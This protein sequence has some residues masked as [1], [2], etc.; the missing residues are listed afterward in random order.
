MISLVPN[1][2]THKNIAYAYFF[3]KMAQNVTVPNPEDQPLTTH[4]QSAAYTGRV[5][6]GYMSRN[7]RAT[8]DLIGAVLDGLTPEQQRRLVET[9]IQR[10]N[11]G[12]L[13]PVEADE[14][15]NYNNNDNNVNIDIID[16]TNNGANQL[17]NQQQNN[18]TGQQNNPGLENNNINGAANGSNRA[19]F[20]DTTPPPNSSSSNNAQQRELITPRQHVSDRNYL[21]SLPRIGLGHT[22]SRHNNGILRQDRFVNENQFRPTRV[23]VER[24]LHQT[25]QHIDELNQQHNRYQHDE[26]DS[27]SFAETR[28]A[29]FNSY[30]QFDYMQPRDYDL[31]SNRGNGRSNQIGSHLPPPPPPSRPTDHRFNE[32]NPSGLLHLKTFDGK[33]DVIEFIE[34]FKAHAIG[35]NWNENAQ[36]RSLRMSLAGRAL[37]VFSQLPESETCTIDRA[38][39][40]LRKHYTPGQAELVTKYFELRPSKNQSTREFLADLADCYHNAYPNA[41]EEQ[42]ILDLRMRVKK[43]LPAHKQFVIPANSRA[44]WLTTIDDVSSECPTLFA[45]DSGESPLKAKSNNIKTDD[46]ELN[47]NFLTNKNQFNRNK[48]TD[49]QQQQQA[50]VQH[51]Q[52]LPVQYQQQP[53]SYQPQLSSTQ[54]QPQFQL[55]VLPQQQYNP[56]VLPNQFMLPPHLYQQ[57]GLQQQQ[58]LP[59]YNMP[60]FQPHGAQ[61]LQQQQQPVNQAAPAQ[62]PQQPQQQKRQFNNNG[63]NASNSDS[64]NRG[65]CGRCRQP[66]H[67]ARICP[68][69]APFKPPAGESKNE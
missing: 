16:D 58:S 38:L 2:R 7:H 6:S 4:S 35:L 46:S 29:P 11:M 33:T 37:K 27:C 9:M 53:L 24:S 61:T 32:F 13:T 12:R 56:F 55:P 39:R 34:S 52:Q 26:N 25:L 14:N 8:D 22:S 23:D 47:V 67:Y 40:A 49:H 44:D 18:N 5:L 68:A 21:D 30:N 28:R 10:G 1:T 63:Q 62:Q 20:V 64:R 42:K 65:E 31:N 15:H 43:L 48:N 50:P 66:G 19:L 3:I 17:N 51:Q 45:V 59:T 60:Q 36:L 54:Q 69:A 57:Y 41:S